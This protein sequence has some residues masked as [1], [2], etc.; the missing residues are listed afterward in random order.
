[1]IRAITTRVG[2]YKLGERLTNRGFQEAGDSPVICR[3][4]HTEAGLAL[5]VLT[6]DES[7]LGFSNARYQHALPTDLRYRLPLR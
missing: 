5:D 1:V 6:Q 3:W 2:H 7:V 4:K